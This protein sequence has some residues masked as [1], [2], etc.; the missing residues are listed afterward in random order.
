MTGCGKH[1]TNGEIIA[2]VVKYW[3]RII[4]MD[5]NELD[6]IISG[7][8]WIKNRRNETNLLKA[9]RHISND[10]GIRNMLPV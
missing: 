3:I 8:S 9:A 1:S 6:I 7:Y 4:R 5:D 10:I 2:K